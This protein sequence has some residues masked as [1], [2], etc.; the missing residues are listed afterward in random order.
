MIGAAIKEAAWIRA[1]AT[2]AVARVIETS[3]TETSFRA[4]TDLFNQGP[5]GEVMPHRA[6]RVTGLRV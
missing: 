4:I 1:E 3:P 6:E 5:S 2:R